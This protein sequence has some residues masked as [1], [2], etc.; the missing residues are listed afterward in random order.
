MIYL[1]NMY[2]YMYTHYN[3]ISILI[4]VQ[5]K[6]YIIESISLTKLTPTNIVIN[7]VLKLGIGLGLYKKLVPTLESRNPNCNPL[8]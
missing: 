6:Y 5:H 4:F 7:T 3:V 1:L 8:V 2:I